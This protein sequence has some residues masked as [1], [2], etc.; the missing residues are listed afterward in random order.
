[1]AFRNASDFSQSLSTLPLDKAQDTRKFYITKTGLCVSA[2]LGRLHYAQDLNLTCAK[3][4][5]N[6]ALFKYIYM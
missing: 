5:C 6:D 3:Q 1:M 2:N 4:S